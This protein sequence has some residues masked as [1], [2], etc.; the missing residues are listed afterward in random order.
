VGG[1]G[2]TEILMQAA[3]NR[4]MPRRRG[5]VGYH[6][7]PRYYCASKHIQLMTAS[8]VHLTNLTTPGSGSTPVWRMVKAPVDDSQ[9]GPCNNQS[10]TRE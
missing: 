7:S 6:S 5:R 8:M 9:Y 3:V 1:S 2:K 4:V 10:N